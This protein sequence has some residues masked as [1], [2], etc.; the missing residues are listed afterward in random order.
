MFDHFGEGRN[1]LAD[2]EP[3]ISTLCAMCK[4]A[5]K[6]ETKDNLHEAVEL[7]EDLATALED[8]EYA[9]ERYHNGQEVIW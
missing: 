4:K 7:I 9:L 3:V 2:A 8:R 5:R 6:Q 1:A